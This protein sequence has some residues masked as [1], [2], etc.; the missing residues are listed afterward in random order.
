MKEHIH[1]GR[2]TAALGHVILSSEHGQARTVTC[3]ALE[4][5]AP[6]R[7]YQCPVEMTPFD[8]Q[9]RSNLSS[10]DSP[11]LTRHVFLPLN[12]S[13][14]TYGV[15]MSSCDQARYEDDINTSVQCL[16]SSLGTLEG[17]VGLPRLSTK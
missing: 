1:F 3:V 4:Q 7:T 12:P 16:P 9:T 11:L 13:I 14:A 2:S 6:L 15:S 5:P 10:F 17:E 8:I